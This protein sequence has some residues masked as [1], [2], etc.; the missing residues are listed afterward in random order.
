MKTQYAGEDV[1]Q[2]PVN[3][4]LRLDP[5]LA[6]TSILS[7]RAVIDT[8]F[9]SLVIVVFTLILGRVWC[10]WLCPMGTAVDL[11]RPFFKSGKPPIDNEKLRTIKYYLLFFL[12]ASSLFSLSL[13]GYLDP[14]SLLTRTLTLSIYPAINALVENSL[15]AGYSSEIGWL[16]RLA[17]SAYSI[18]KEY[19]LAFEQPIYYLNFF[20]VFIFLAILFLERFQKR[21]WC[22]NLCPLGALLALLSPFS[23]IKRKP[24]KQCSDCAHGCDGVCRLN[25]FK[26]KFQEK[27]IKNE[28][29]YCFDCIDKCPNAR[30]RYFLGFGKEPTGK[31]QGGKVDL[32]RRGF[33]YSAGA[34]A[35]ALPLLRVHPASAAER[36]PPTFIRPPGAAPEAEFSAKCLRCGECMRVCVKNAIQPSF[37][38]AGLEGLWTPKIVP[39]IGY[40]EFDCTLCGQVCPSQALKKLTIEEKHSFVIGKAFFDKN[41]CIPYAKEIDCI[42]CEEHCP[43]LPKK[44]I[45]FKEKEIIDSEGNRKIVKQPFVD[46]ELCIGCG[47]C[48]NK[49]PLEKRA[50]IIVFNQKKIIKEGYFISY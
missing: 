22:R 14:L 2:Y 29:I 19:V 9:I 8:F 33:L 44:A 5:L 39:R 34:G 41:R 48:E 27:Q 43:T 46:E 32:T 42:V 17:D 30:V 23:I 38:E 31:K 25:L 28:C 16:S 21:F 18:A 12:I 1:L 45:N 40:C 35:L 10:G 24:A 26:G 36:L 15:L 47:I 11:L 50:G 6:L 7:A 49:C 37:F 13:A 20:T 4:F 3:I